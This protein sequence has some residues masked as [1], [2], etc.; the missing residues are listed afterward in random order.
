MNKML[1]SSTSVLAEIL[2]RYISVEKYNLALIKK[3]NEYCNIF[4]FIKYKQSNDKPY[5]IISLIIK[6]FWVS[7]L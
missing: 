4:M 1:F 6:Y 7:S 5:D 2:Y 3:I